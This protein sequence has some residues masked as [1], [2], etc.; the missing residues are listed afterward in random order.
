MADAAKPLT[1][2]AIKAALAARQARAQVRE[3]DAIKGEPIAIVGLGC[4][5]PGG[6]DSP[7][8]FWTLLERG[9]D[10]ITEVPRERW[11]I[12]ALY[13]PDPAVPGRM[14]TRWG[15]FL[16]GVDLFDPKFFGIAPREAASMDPQQRLLL[17]VSWEALED[18]GLTQSMLAGSDTGVFFA[19]YNSDYATWRVLDPTRIDAYTGLGTAHSI[20][21]GRLSFLFDLQGPSVVVDTACSSSL[22][23]VHL[24]CQSLRTGESRV[25]VAGGVSLVLSPEMAI[26]LSKWGFM[27]GDGRCK[28][29]DAN[30]D[31]FVRGEGCGVVVLKRLSDALADGD[32]V[33]AVIRGSAVNQDGRSAVLTAPSGP[34]QEAV[35]RRALAMGGVDPSEVSYVEAHGTG[36]SLG[37]PIEVEALASVLGQ[38]AT[39]RPC[40][41]ASV[42]TNIGHLEA[43][44]GVA[45]LIKVVLALEHERIPPH[46]HFQSLNPHVSVEGTRLAIQAEGRPWPSTEGR[47]FAGVSSF[48][49]GGTNAHVVVEEAPLVAVESDRTNDGLPVQILPLTAASEEA[50]KDTAASYRHFLSRDDAPAIGAVCRTAA[51]RRTHHTHRL[52]ALGASAQEIA[53]ALDAYLRGERCGDIVTGRASAGARTGPVFVFCGQ[54]PQRWDMG[55]ELFQLLAFRNAFEACAAA[56]DPLAGF[57]LAKEFFADEASSRMQ[58]TVVAQPA[59]FALQVASAALWRSWG[60]APAAVV[61]HSVGEIAAAHVAGVLSLQDAAS[62]VVARGRIMQRATGQGR[63]VSVRASAERLADVV[64]AHR[65]LLSV[66]ARNG[67]DTTVLSGHP[68]AVLTAARELEGQ[69]ITCRVLP[70]N[71]AFHSYQMAPLAGDLAAAFRD[72]RSR[73]GEVPFIST[74]AGAEV[75]GEECGPEYWVR[76][77]TQPVAFREG[78]L[79]LGARR[80][81]LFVEIGPHPVLTSAIDEC[82]SEASVNATV[83][84]SLQRD[85][86][87]LLSMLAGFG[88]LFAR[89]AA[90]DWTAV[91]PQHA[92]VVSLPAYAWQRQRYWIGRP[93]VTTTGSSAGSAEGH[94]LAGIRLRSAAFEGFVFEALLSARGP[95]FLADHVI[96]G[97]VLMPATG[98]IAMALSAGERAFGVSPEIRDLVIGEPLVLGHEARRVQTVLECERSNGAPFRIVSQNPDDEDAWIE[99]AAGR[100]LARRDVRVGDIRLPDVPEDAEPLAPAD[101]YEAMR[102]SGCEFGETFRGIRQLRRAGTH[103]WAEIAASLDENAVHPYAVHPAVLDAALQC[104]APAVERVHGP[105][106]TWIPYS[107]GRVSLEGRIGSRARAHAVVDSAEHQQFVKGRVEARDE[108]GRG[109]IVLEDVTLG[110]AGRARLAAAGARVPRDWFYVLDWEPAAA[111][112]AAE[113]RS[114]WLI[115]GDGGGVG[116]RLAAALQAAGDTC[117]LAGA[118]RAI[119]VSPGGSLVEACARSGRLRIAYLAAL[120]APENRSIGA[121]DSQVI[122]QKVY[123]GALELVQRV[124]RRELQPDALW[125]VTSGTQ[126]LPGG[127]D[128]PHAVGASL[129][130]LRR[131]VALEHPEVPCL[132]VDAGS[133]G[134]D[135]TALVHVLRGSTDEPEVG[136]TG[137]ARLVPRLRRQSPP[138]T[139]DVERVAR[140]VPMPRGVLDNLALVTDSRREPGPGEVELRVLATGLNFRDVLNALGMY[141]GDP[142]PLGDECCGVVTR[143]GAGAD[144]FTPGDEVLGIAHGAFATHAVTHADLLVRRPKMLSAAEAAGIPIPFLTAEYALNEVGRLRRGER[145]LIHAAAGGVGLAAV[146]LAQEVGA[147]IFATA[148]SPEKHAFLRSLGIEH[149]FSSRTPDFVEAIRARTGGRGV[150]LV[151]NSLTGEFIPRSFDVLVEGGRFM[152]IGRLGI[153]SQEQAKEARPDVAYTVVFMGD[154]FATDRD[155]SQRMLASIMTRIERGTLRPI[156]LRHFTLD[157]AVDAFRHMALAQHI[158]KVVVTQPAALPVRIRQDAT[159]LLTGGGGALGL[160]VARWLVSAGARH[161][162][163][164]GRSEPSASARTALDELTAAGAR[165]RLVGADV[166]SAA[167]TRAVLDALSDAPPLGGI[168]HAAG[169]LD[170]GVIAQQDA[171]RFARV[172]AP[173]LGGATLVRTL[174]E[175]HRP[176]FVVLF[177]SGASVLGSHAQ[178]NYA[179]ANAFLDAFAADLRGAGIRAW[180]INWGAWAQTGMAASMNDRDR[181]RLRERGHGTIAPAQGVA[182]LGRILQ[183][184]RAPQVAVLPIDWAAFVRHEPG[185]HVRP[186]LSGVAGESGVGAQGDGTAERSL[187]EELARVSPAERRERL[188]AHVREEVTKVLGLPPGSSLDP[189][190]GLRDVGLDSL[191]AV[192]LKNRLQTSVGAVLPATLAFDY[193]TPAALVQFLAELLQIAPAVDPCK[194]APAAQAASAAER[195][196]VAALSD[197]EAEALLV[198]ELSALD[199][200]SHGR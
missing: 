194:P 103:S 132:C 67:R 21:A 90:V 153:W 84:P 108:Q 78:V 77:V 107:I 199:R 9:T 106:R 138:R 197:A 88:A 154:L 101:H 162:V 56:I 157:R 1:L 98:F 47:R 16:A 19:I 105:G 200:E 130:G 133:L 97:N 54:G 193:P 52:A 170:D 110:R 146:Q 128:V 38:P 43:A 100:L 164:V 180:S 184:D 62:I 135:L 33:H 188:A 63:M 185:G 94:P 117:T 59:L 161:L 10:A 115:V 39:G 172:L 156:R 142:G 196:D 27:A 23:A 31:G 60:V 116:V 26:G 89:G 29:F 129:W 119:D 114:H 109:A 35:I 91:V 72:V 147:E 134:R 174:C 45:G 73:R 136:L 168:I 118:V 191:M 121:E 151:L 75:S 6:G 143:V 5:F 4:R 177:S 165:V 22:V 57:A 166:A 99:H 126:C 8:A 189:H 95:A 25:A 124:A 82:L 74:V 55:R 41:L 176:D 87:A 123:A 81:D 195:N 30:A 48:G 49:F 192:E 15:A 68:D 85:R 79:A 169:T 131:T 139:P 92:P 40:L 32:R 186:L 178:A 2:S 46:L 104:L 160:H 111:S 36:T 53:G 7:Q 93:D 144:R 120:D 127:G 141:P 182:A 71:Y 155:R 181:A 167:A 3:L 69:G 187:V 61:G 18:A 86:P 163:L 150:D 145:V 112:P 24:A 17:E 159:Y 66:A 137:E 28:T 122:A 83:V 50:L 14:N 148:G 42:K 12:D 158:G 70:V 11:N 140:L 58:A 65:G 113:E 51:L 44:A 179:A 102:A 175:A 13:D 198:A 64:A 152:E 171:S 76:N 190:Q 96:H 37:D 80:H 183:D 149:V 173:K 34:S 20:A 125:F